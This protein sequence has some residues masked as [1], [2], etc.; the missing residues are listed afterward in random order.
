MRVRPTIAAAFGVLALAGPAFA[1]TP[2]PDCHG[3]LL[4]DAD[5]DQF[6]G[7]SANFVVRPPVAIDIDDVFLTGA[8][9]AEKV[10][11]RVADLTA[12]QKNI[13]YSFRWDD[14]ANF[15]YSYELTASFLGPN[16]IASGGTYS[17]WR[18]DP[19]GS[20]ISLTN[21]S[22]TGFT[23]PQGVVRWD[24]PA[25]VTWP[26]TFTGVQVRAEQYETN[27]VTEVAL[28]ADTAAATSWAQ[29]C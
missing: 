10:N 21:A 3:L 14:P 28:R 22:G 24:K 15:G 27:A 6:I 20:W 9:G 2:V 25:S 23:G 4:D 5:D 11:L 8:S 17:L 16:G 19:S 26:A 1:A 18:L 13:Q 12:T 29:P 7:T